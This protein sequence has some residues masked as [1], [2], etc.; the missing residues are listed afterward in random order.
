MG[1][2]KQYGFVV[3]EIARGIK[4]LWIKLLNTEKILEVL[5]W[6]PDALLN[7]MTI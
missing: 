6:T 2:I 4:L 3:M 7:D 1:Y 5:Q